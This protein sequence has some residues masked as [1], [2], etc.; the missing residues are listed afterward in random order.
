MLTSTVMAISPLET[1][2]SFC[3][4][5]AW[6]YL[7]DS[8]VSVFELVIEMSY[9]CGESYLENEKSDSP[10][11]DSC[12]NCKAYSICTNHIL[13]FTDVGNGDQ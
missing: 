1:V 6:P 8:G 2:E 4:I 13:D 3:S 10:R 12:G 9:K 7:Q 11:T 5:P